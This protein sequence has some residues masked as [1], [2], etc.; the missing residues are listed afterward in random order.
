MTIIIRDAQPADRPALFDVWAEAVDATHAFLTENDRLHIA[1]LVRDQYLPSATL[2]VGEVEGEPAGF[3][4]A[5]LDGAWL[6]IDSLFVRPRHFRKG[7]GRALLEHVAK[8]GQPV[9]LD[10]NEGNP[11]ALVFYQRLGF[12]QTGRSETDDGGR[13]YPLLHLER[14]QKGG[15]AS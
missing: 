15:A 1:E 11:D 5:R 7:V 12:V 2:L 13:P 4:G 10:V 6:V 9:R 14:A 3:L 8:P